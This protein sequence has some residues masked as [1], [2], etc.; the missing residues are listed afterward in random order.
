MSRKARTLSSAS[1][2][3]RREDRQVRRPRRDGG[4]SLSSRPMARP[5]RRLLRRAWHCGRSRG[6]VR[7]Y[8]GRRFRH[9]RPFPRRRRGE[10]FQRGGATRMAGSARPPAQAAPP[11]GSTPT[12]GLSCRV[13]GGPGASNCFGAAFRDN[14]SSP[15]TSPARRDQATGRSPRAGP[16]MSDT[17]HDAIHDRTARGTA[18]THPWPVNAIAFA[19]M[20]VDFVDRIIVG[21]G[22]RT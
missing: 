19:L 22:C 5:T 10:N 21:R 17:T 3:I 8:A 16:S 12:A 1:R 20:V 6:A 2:N 9:L 7:R 18:A 4:A 13:A 11:P 15:A 14:A